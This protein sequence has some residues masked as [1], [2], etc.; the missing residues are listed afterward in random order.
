M[1][2]D[3]GRHPRQSRLCSSFR[4]DY[5]SAFTSRTVG[6][7]FEQ[8]FRTSHLPLVLPLLHPSILLL[9]KISLL[10]CGDYSCGGVML[11]AALGCIWNLL[12]VLCWLAAS[13]LAL[14]AHCTHGALQPRQHQLVLSPV[15]ISEVS[16]FLSSEWL[17]LECRAVNR[18]RFTHMPWQS[19]SLQE[20]GRL[21][22]LP[23][24]P[25]QLRIGSED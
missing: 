4:S 25:P 23:P 11:S 21:P 5:K 19:R 9:F 20:D 14:G 16:R 3:F 18:L 13:S 10:G 22:F 6:R 7:G 2:R 17:S 12:R 24:S 15:L 8:S 1:P